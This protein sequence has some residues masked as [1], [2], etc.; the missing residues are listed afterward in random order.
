[1]NQMKIDL[2]TVPYAEIGDTLGSFVLYNADAYGLDA[3]EIVDEMDDAT[4]FKPTNSEI[5]NL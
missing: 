3:G 1:M 5:H 2:T 4:N